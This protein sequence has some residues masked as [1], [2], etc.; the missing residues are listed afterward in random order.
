VKV[1]DEND[2]A[3]KFLIRE[4]KATIPSNLTTHSGFLKVGHEVYI[5]VGISNI[6]VTHNS[7]LEVIY[8]LCFQFTP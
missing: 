6:N 2:N 5:P 8:V 1:T 3:P 7:N 4:Y